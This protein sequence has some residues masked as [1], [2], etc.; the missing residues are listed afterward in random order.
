MA[1]GGGGHA[2]LAETMSVF[3]IPVMSKKSF[4]ATEK[5]I[6]GNWWDFLEESMKEAAEE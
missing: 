1:T 2:P 6:A 3:G 5:E 4:M